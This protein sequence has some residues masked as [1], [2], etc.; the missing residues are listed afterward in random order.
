MPNTEKKTIEEEFFS[1]SDRIVKSNALVGSK[2]RASLNELRLTAY[3]LSRIPD[4]QVDARGGLVIEM[5]AGELKDVLNVSHRSGSFYATLSRTAEKMVGRTLGIRDPQNNRFA[6]MPFIDLAVYENSCL[7]VRFVPE[8]SKYLRDLSS[9]YTVY[10]LRLLMQWSSVYSYRIFECLKAR[11]YYPKDAPKGDNKFRIWYSVSELKLEIGAINPD[12]GKVKE[13]LQTSSRNGAPDW[14]RACAA[15][16][17][18]VYKDWP[19]FKRDVLDKAIKEINSNEQASM[20]IEYTLQRGAKRKVTGITFFVDTNPHHERTGNPGEY[21][22]VPAEK[23][24]LSEDEKLEILDQVMGE[25]EEKISIL[26]AKKIAEAADYDIDKVRLAYSIACGSKNID[27]I[28]G[29]M[30]SAI[31]DGY[32]PPKRKAGRPRKNAFNNFEQRDTD[33]NELLKD[34]Y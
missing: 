11:C 29:W 32:E 10:S 27:N 8:M 21:I 9:S 30:I 6:F 12:I 3:M 26:D 17:D 7:R 1:P 23:R 33:Y 4:A 2:Y 34:L 14:D 19:I 16:K 18:Q 5:G 15:A 31:K 28:V 24:M 20:H 22:E 13:I 25:I